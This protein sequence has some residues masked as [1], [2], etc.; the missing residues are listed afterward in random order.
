MLKLGK[1]SFKDN[2]HA[3]LSFNLQIKHV[4]FF[5]L[6]Q[7][8][9]ILVFMLTKKKEQRTFYLNI[10]LLFLNHV[11]YYG[12]SQN[13][14][15]QIRIKNCFHFPVSD[16]IENKTMQLDTRCKFPWKTWQCYHE[17]TRKFSSV[18]KVIHYKVHRLAPIM[19]CSLAKD[20][21]E[22]MSTY[23]DLTHKSILSRHEQSN[24]QT[25]MLI[26]HM[27]SEDIYSKTILR[28]FIKYKKLRYH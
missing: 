17:N 16:C 21:P 18:R 22:V 24:L 12:E 6:F 2:N 25:P 28:N 15:Q 9:S 26:W 1:S 11:I 27:N 7:A 20:V 19:T 14:K 23:Q 8:I 3:V 13:D 10:K 4:K 5:F